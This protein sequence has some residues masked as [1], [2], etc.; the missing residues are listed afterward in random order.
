MMKRL[1]LAL[2]PRR[3]HLK[4]LRRLGRWQMKLHFDEPLQW[5]ACRWISL[6]T[7]DR[8]ERVIWQMPGTSL[9]FRLDPLETIQMNLYYR[10]NF[11]PEIEYWVRHSLVP[12]R[13]FIDAGANIG[14]HSLIAADIYRNNSGTL[15]EAPVCAFEPNPRIY[16]QLQSNICENGLQQFISAHQIAVSD[17]NQTAAFYLSAADNSACS[18]L[19][20]LGSGHSQTWQSVNVRTVDLA[21]FVQGREGNMR[22]GLIKLDI[23]GAELIA[24]RG[25]K[26]LL[27]RDH[28]I[29]IVEVYP[30]LLHRFGFTFAD[31][32]DFIRPLGYK[33]CR[34]KPDRTLAD[35]NQGEWPSE[36]EYGDMICIPY[37]REVEFAGAS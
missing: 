34:I 6:L 35:L 10:G 33:F 24:L 20:P 5:R 16:A 4:W 25:A 13:L 9:R 18:S 8:D 23:E 31:V 11:Q 26:Q 14:I 22:V 29:L 19:A 2:Y 27:S 3:R 1:R 28:P 7:T 21:S 32:R 12:N 37:D 36:I 15:A 30:A 17:M